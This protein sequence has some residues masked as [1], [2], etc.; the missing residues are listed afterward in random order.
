MALDSLTIQPMTVP[1]VAMLNAAML[2]SVTSTLLHLL[3]RLAEGLGV[4]LKA[5]ICGHP[6]TPLWP[7]ITNSFQ[8]LCA[9]VLI[10]STDINVCCSI[11]L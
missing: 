3:N 8:K 10:L 2:I 9:D 7:S 6:N 5:L 4:I 11:L 1:L